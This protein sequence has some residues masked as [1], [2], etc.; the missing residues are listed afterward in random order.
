MLESSQIV[1]KLSLVVAALLWSGLAI[2]GL[3]TTLVFLWHCCSTYVKK[4]HVLFL[5]DVFLSV[6]KW[7]HLLLGVCYDHV[8]LCEL[9]ETVR[10]KI[11]QALDENEELLYHAGMFAMHLLASM[12]V[13]IFEGNPAAGSDSDGSGSGSGSVGAVILCADLRPSRKC[14]KEGQRS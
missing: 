2:I 9:L 12:T 11:Q 4:S 10:T 13:F 5:L 6:P 3:Y 1:L 8:P 14:L 7:M